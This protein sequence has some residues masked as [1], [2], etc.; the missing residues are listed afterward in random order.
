MQQLEKDAAAASGSSD[1]SDDLTRG[2]RQLEAALNSHIDEVEKPSGLLDQIE[3]KAPRLQR[4]VEETKRHHVVLNEMVTTLL[5]LIAS[6][7]ESEPPLTKNIRA[8]IVDLLTELT[9]HRQA[10][11]DLIYEAYDV[12]IGGY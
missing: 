1:W 7:P 11:A 4:K 8:T 12:D 10:G 9:R 2:V 3:D 6:A 5:E